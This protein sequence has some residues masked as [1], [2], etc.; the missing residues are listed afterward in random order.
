MNHDQVIDI[1]DVTMLIS[2]VLGTHVEGFF[3]T[4]ADVNGEEPIDVADITALIG[5]VLGMN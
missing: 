3:V 2:Y 5:R 4:E 1:E